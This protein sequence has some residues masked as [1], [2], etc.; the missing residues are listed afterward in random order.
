MTEAIQIPFFS[1]T[2]AVYHASSVSAL[3]NFL[4]L[5][6][7]IDGAVYCAFGVFA[8]EQ[9]PYITNGL[10]ALGFIAVTI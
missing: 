6:V 3:R 2:E 9:S 5:T 1:M 10:T 8:L 4:H 7:S